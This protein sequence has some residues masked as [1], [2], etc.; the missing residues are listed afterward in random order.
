MLKKHCDAEG[1]DP[2]TKIFTAEQLKKA[3]DNYSQSR[4]LGQGG[5][6]TVYKGV[7][8]DKRVVA[9][10]KSKL[11]DDNQIEY[12]INEIMLLSQVNHR[13]V[14]KLLGCCLETEVPLLVY[15]FIPNGTLFNRIHDPIS[16]PWKERLQIAADAA[17]AIA[18]LHS[19]ASPPIIHRDIKSTNI[20]LDEKYTAKISDFG[21]SRAMPFDQTHVTTVVQGT[22][23]Y[24]DPEYFTTHQLTEKSDVYSF[25]VVLAE[26]WLREKTI[27]T[28]RPVEIQGLAAYFNMIASQCQLAQLMEPYVVE[29][30]GVEQIEAVERLTDRCLILKAEERP[31][32]KEVASELDRLRKAMEK[33]S[34]NIDTNTLILFS[35][36]PSGQSSHSGIGGEE[37]T[38]QYSLETSM[39]SSMELPR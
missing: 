10:K 36:D 29:E 30:A 1:I 32:M 4:V 34:T 12:F 35:N 33:D 11:S 39:I 17:G 2:K 5:F 25:G 38:R 14:V 31:T 27:S 21:A 23:G 18:Y 37:V 9:I 3:T 28:D 8:H 19:A 6:G 16:F 13:N 24:L 15:E 7:L 22:F 26:L 20:L